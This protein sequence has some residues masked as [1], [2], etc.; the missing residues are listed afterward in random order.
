MAS[1]SFIHRLIHGRRRWLVLGSGLLLIGLLIVGRPQDNATP[2]ET[3]A[4]IT[5]GALE[6]SVTAQGT[7][8]P[9]E[10]VDVGAQ[11]SGQLL[12]VNV[13]IG[14][15]VKKGQLLAEIDPRVYLA[16]E[17]A[18]I[19]KLKSLR[20]QLA[21][22]E[23]QTRLTKRIY[24][25]NK[26]L[27]K[28]KAVAQE[29]L[30][31]SAANYT[32]AVASEKSLMAQIEEQQSALE[33]VQANLSYTKIYAPIDGTVTAQPVR[34]GQTLNTMQSAPTILQVAN[35]DVMTARAQV[36]EADVSRVKPGMQVYFTTLGAGERRWVGTVRQIEP[37]P[38]LVNDVVL[39][40]ALVDAD[41]Q[42]RAL[43]MDM[44]AQMFFVIGK[45]DNALLIPT[46]ALL[47]PQPEKNTAQGKAY[48]VR[49]K[50][51][52]KTQEQLVHIGMMTRTQAEL[53]DGLNEGDRVVLPTAAS[54]TNANSG[55]M[56]RPAMMGPRL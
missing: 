6:E 53:L 23:A 21:Q 13:A 46:Q 34:A 40:N 45:V 19:A 31:T 48:L 41:N 33:A 55:S 12:R 15:V 43:M 44:S 25:R 4:P 39:Y 20:A 36:A 18:A 5:R 35:L 26:A 2:T 49:V 32:V 8:E 9:K 38:E 17:E 11:V 42:D 54:T 56:R 52:K 30:D 51:G 10:Y 37:T 50:S 22:Q 14:E 29:E 7:L 1:V 24:E 28:D 27:L 47:K 16:N 3:T